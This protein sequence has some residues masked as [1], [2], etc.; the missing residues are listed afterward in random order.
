MTAIAHKVKSDTTIDAR[1]AKVTVRVLLAVAPV[2]DTLLPAEVACLVFRWAAQGNV[3][4][5]ELGVFPLLQCL[6]RRLGSRRV[7]RTVYSQRRCDSRCNSAA[8]RPVQPLVWAA[9]CA[10]GGGQNRTAKSRMNARCRSH[11]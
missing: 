3:M 2:V 10:R 5:R 6:R 1:L 4:R 11:L 9:R 7:S 8:S